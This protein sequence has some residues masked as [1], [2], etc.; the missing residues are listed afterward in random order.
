MMIWDPVLCAVY[1]VCTMLMKYANV[2]M[3]PTT[4]YLLDR[5]RKIISR[6]KLALAIN[7]S[8][9]KRQD[10]APYIKVPYPV[11]AI[12]VSPSFQFSLS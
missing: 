11:S 9:S 1:T 12:A 10:H 4:T 7:L 2:T 3:M 6:E 5:P 8:F